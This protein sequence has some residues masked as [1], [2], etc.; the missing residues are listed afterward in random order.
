MAAIAA[1]LLMVPWVG[2]VS[3]ELGQVQIEGISISAVVT[4]TLAVL[5]SIVSWSAL[6]WRS[7][8]IRTVGVL[9][10]V[11][12]AASLI[13]PFIQVVGPVTSVLVGAVAGFSATMF[14]KK[15]T[16]PTRNRPVVIATITLAATHLILTLL[17]LSTQGSHVW[18]TDDGIGAWTGTAEGI[19]RGFMFNDGI[20]FVYLAVIVPSLVATVWA[21][22]KENED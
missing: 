13:I 17:I 7:K 10:S 19:E 21:I 20:E 11:I 5:F 18:D 3:F 12:T 14:Q 8:N 6:S 4:M 16:S 1:F 22:R 2:K 9:L 15:M